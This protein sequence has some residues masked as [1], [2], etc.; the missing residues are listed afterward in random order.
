MPAR[1]HGQYLNPL[2]KVWSAMKRRCL[3]PDDPSYSNYGGR[4]ISIYPGWMTFKP[5]YT[6]AME[7]GYEKGLTI[8]RRDNDGNYEPLNCA[9]IPKGQQ[10]NN[11][12][13]CRIIEFKGEK[14]NIK[15]WALILR[16]PHAALRSRFKYGWSVEKAFTVP[17]IPPQLRH[18]NERMKEEIQAATGIPTYAL[19]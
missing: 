13:R 10:T 3:S 11:T 17:L 1:T 14:H 16:I 7:N 4:G 15:E 18:A 5:F 8:E 9:W 12:R 6:W 2:Y 19:K